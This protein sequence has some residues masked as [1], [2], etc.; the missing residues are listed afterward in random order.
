MQAQTIADLI[1]NLQ[2]RSSKIKLS[3]KDRER[4]ER[5]FDA[6]HAYHSSRLEEINGLTL[7]EVKK[8]F[9]KYK[10]WEAYAT[11][12]LWKVVS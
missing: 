12:Y 8:I 6:E 3:F 1:I 2:K 9:K 10:G 5:E 11:L 7:D 4:F